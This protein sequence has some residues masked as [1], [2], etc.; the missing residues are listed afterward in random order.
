LK[1][2][3]FSSLRNFGLSGASVSR[4]LIPTI[5]VVSASSAAIEVSIRRRLSGAS[6]GRRAR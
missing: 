5:A 1:V 6:A 4:A 3:T 2:P